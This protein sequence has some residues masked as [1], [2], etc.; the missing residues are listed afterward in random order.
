MFT[1]GT[2]HGEGDQWCGD[3]LYQCVYSMSRS[4]QIMSDISERFSELQEWVE[5]QSVVVW[6]AVLLGGFVLLA[7]AQRLAQVSAT[8]LQTTPTVLITALLA[9]VSL[10]VSLAAFGLATWGLALDFRDR[11]LALFA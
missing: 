11:D 6:P 4:D 1:T 3:Y 5:A 7:V 9:T 8:T 2:R 10:V